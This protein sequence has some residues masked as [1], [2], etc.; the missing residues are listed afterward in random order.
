MKTLPYPGFPTD[1]QPQMTSFLLLAEGTSI[2]SER[3]FEDRFGHVDEL[4][5]LGGRIKTEGRT[6]VIEGVERLTGAPVTATD[7]RQGRAWSSRGWPPRARRSSTVWNTWTGG[8]SGWRRSWPASGPGSTG[9]KRWKS[10]SGCSLIWDAGASAGG[11]RLLFLPFSSA[12][13]RILGAAEGVGGLGLRPGPPTGRLP[14][15]VSPH[16]PQS[17]KKL[18]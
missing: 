3:I 9:S 4:K 6:A 5:R 1:L 15:R 13:L 12:S 18:A 16:D 17:E 8:T 14:S 11:V 2:V 7:L 10:G